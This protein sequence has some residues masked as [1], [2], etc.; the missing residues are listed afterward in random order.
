MADAPV[1]MAWIP[2]GAF[3][4]DGFWLDEQPLT[5]AEFRRS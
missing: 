1:G 2:G 3:P 4:V 5:V